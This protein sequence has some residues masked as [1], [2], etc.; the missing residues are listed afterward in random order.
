MLSKQAATPWLP[1]MKDKPQARLRLFCF[2]SA[3]GWSNAFYPWSDALPDKVLVCPVSLPGRERL[4]YE[5]AFTSLPNL[6]KPLAAAL[7]PS[8][9][10]P[11]AFFGHSMGALI[12]FELAR[13]LRR[14][15]RAGPAALFVS[16]H[17][18]PQLPR[19]EQFTTYDLPDS[20]FIEEVRRLNGTPR[21]VLE[22][23]ELM[24]LMLPVLRAD[25]EVVETY[26]YAAEAPLNCP[27]SVFGGGEDPEVSVEELEAWREQSTGPFSLKM[28]PGGH[29]FIQTAPPLFLSELSRQLH[30]L[31]EGMS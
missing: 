14:E 25:L 31:V 26:E 3:G 7:R 11:F 6:V 29:F 9:D 15:N 27:I 8:L 30:P 20:Q 13:L 2:P 5:P 18:A 17:R 23:R 10:E 21:A 22:H 19:R 28:L 24:D 16:A 1:Y 4:L 12:G